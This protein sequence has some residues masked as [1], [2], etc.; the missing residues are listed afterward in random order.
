MPTYYSLEAQ[1][2]WEPFKMLQQGLSARADR[3]QRERFFKSQETRLKEQDKLNRMQ[4]KQAMKINKLNLQE[5]QQEKKQKTFLR[6]LTPDVFKPTMTEQFVPE[7]A[8]EASIAAYQKSLQGPIDWNKPIH[9][10]PPEIQQ[11]VANLAA[12]GGVSLPDVA[13]QF[14]MN[15]QFLGKPYQPPVEAPQVPGMVPTAVQVQTP[16]GATVSY[17]G[18][19]STV[20][21][22]GMQVTQ[23]SVGP[24]GIPTYTM[25]PSEFIQEE[26]EAVRVQKAKDI[27]AISSV[28]SYSKA[29]VQLGALNKLVAFGKANAESGDWNILGPNDMALIFTYMKTIDP[30]SV[31][32]EGEFRSAKMTGSKLDEMQTLWSQ[33]LNGQMLTQRQ[34]EGFLTAARNVIEEYSKQAQK[35]AKVVDPNFDTSSLQ[36]APELR[37][38]KFT[39]NDIREADTLFRGGALQYGDQIE[40]RNPDGRYSKYT[41]APRPT[42]GSMSVNPGGPQ[43]TAPGQ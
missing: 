30:D 35:D 36:I 9:L 2:F 41:W 27:M 32:R 4:V 34:R 20:V 11:R 16:Q 43:V 6:G 15:R 1:G 24:D 12:E 22:P 14:E 5:A 28:K 23:A 42:Q 3:A 13:Q 38:V 10:Q 40:I 19:A 37:G 29:A 25:K 39:V 33:V 7:G 31:V 17:R 18:E 8:D 26:R 21:P